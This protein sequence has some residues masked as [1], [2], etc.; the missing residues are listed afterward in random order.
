M[1][2]DRHGA[3]RPRDDDRPRLSSSLPFCL[4]HGRN[5]GP[6]FRHQSHGGLPHNFKVYSKI[7]MDETIAHSRHPLPWNSRVPASHSRRNVLGGLTDDL[8]S[9]KHGKVCL[10]ILLGPHSGVTS[11]RMRSPR[12]PLSALLVT[13]ST[14]T[15]SN[16]VR[17]SSSSANSNN[18][19]VS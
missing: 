3:A 18:V 9:T 13:S 10:D 12:A 19:G 4:Q 6:Q 5:L 7:T 17:C 14:F 16:V 15:R 11:S 2:G 8:Q 1:T